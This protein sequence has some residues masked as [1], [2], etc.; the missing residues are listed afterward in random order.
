MGYLI[1]SA[2]QK[3]WRFASWGSGMENIRDTSFATLTQIEN[4]VISSP[5][6]LKKIDEYFILIFKCICTES[7]T[8][9]KY[10]IWSDRIKQYCEQWRL[11]LHTNIEKQE[12]FLN[13]Y[14]VVTYSRN[15]SSHQIYC[16]GRLKSPVTLNPACS[17]PANRF[18]FLTSR[19]I[20]YW[21]LLI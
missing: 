15:E 20:I 3:F 5:R 10:K 9:L 11:I 18:W 21:A 16:T 12:A 1:T 8:I 7:I 13:E 14:G 2:K 6:W 17:L 19:A 4:S